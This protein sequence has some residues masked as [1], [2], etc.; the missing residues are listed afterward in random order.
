MSA[1]MRAVFD[2]ALLLPEA[3]R[4]ELAERLYDSLSSQRQEE[5]ERAWIEEA[6]RRLDAYD[7]GLTKAVS[8][9]EVFRELLDEQS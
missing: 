3:A 5:I 6:E 8:G 2:A 7:R 4:A 1:D 9:E